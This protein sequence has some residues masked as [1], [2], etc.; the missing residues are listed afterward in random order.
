MLPVRRQGVEATGA[1][2]RGGSHN[3]RQQDRR[4]PTGVI[5][6]RQGAE[7]QRRRGRDHARLLVRQYPRAERRV[8]AQEKVGAQLDRVYGDSPLTAG[9]RLTA[10]PVAL[11]LAAPISGALYDRVGARLL[12]VAGTLTLLASSLMLAYVLGAGASRLALLTGLLNP[13]SVRVDALRRPRR[14]TRI[15]PMPSRIPKAAQNRQSDV[16]CRRW[17]CTSPL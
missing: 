3:P 8:V 13:R 5:A 14:R 15:H 16:I 11:A 7:I 2:V 6:W 17:H 4:R 9:L 1:S 10:I 12:K